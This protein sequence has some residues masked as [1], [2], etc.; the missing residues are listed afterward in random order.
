MK[1]FKAIVL[2]GSEEEAELVLSNIITFFDG[3]TVMYL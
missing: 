1:T 3:F 2:Y